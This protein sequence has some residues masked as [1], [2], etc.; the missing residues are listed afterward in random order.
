MHATSPSSIYPCEIIFVRHGESELNVRAA[1]ALSRHD[2]LVKLRR[3]TRDA[4]VPLTNT[5]RRQAEVTGQA[6][7]DNFDKIDIAYTSP[8]LRAHD[9]LAAI[10]KGLG[11]SVEVRLED[12]VREKEFGIIGQYTIYGMKKHFPQEAERLEL[13]GPYYYRPLGG[14]SYPDIGL[15]LHSFLHSLYSHQAGKRVLVVTHAAVISM[16]RKMLEYLTE[17]AML[18]IEDS[19]VAHNCSVTNYK[20]GDERLVLDYYNKVYY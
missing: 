13:E 1:I 10:Q 18:D 15:R 14:E 11:Y 4:D 16:V 19:H 8:H 12:R 2:T 9:T 20:V 6:L 17:A 5:G 7:A 3:P